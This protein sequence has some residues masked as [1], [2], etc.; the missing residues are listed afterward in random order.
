MS[1]GTENSMSQT[2]STSVLSTDESDQAKGQSRLTRPDRDSRRSWVIAAIAAI[3]GSGSLIALFLPL[4]PEALGLAACLLMLILIFLRMPVGVAMVIPS[5]LGMRAL[6]G[7]S[8]VEAAV[9]DVPYTAVANWTLSVVPMFILM[10]LLLWR[11]G[12]TTSVYEAGRQWLSWLPGGLAVGTNAAGAGLASV[13]GSTV[14]TTYALARTGIPEMLRAGYHKRVAISAVMTSGLPGQLIPPSILLVIYAGIA[15]VPVGPQL[16]A[17]VGPGVAVALMF[18]AMFVV[19]A[20]ARPSLT[21]GRGSENGDHDSG[22][23]MEDPSWRTRVR[24]LREVWPVPLIVA[25]IGWGIFSG[26]FTA[27]E[28]GALA[29]LLALVVTVI[30]QF[31]QGPFAAVAAAT[32]DAVSS[33]GAIFFI[34]LGVD[35]LSRMLSLSG[36]SAALVDVV[37]SLGLGRIEFLLVMTV[38]Y[39]ILGT[40][41]E[42]LPM[43][44]LTV[45]ALLPTLETLDISLIWFGVFVVFMGEIAVLSPPVGILAFIIHSIAQEPEVNLGQRITLKDVFMSLV[46]FL[47]IAVAF[48]VLIILVPEVVTYLPELTSP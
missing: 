20:M 28:A 12:L 4:Q 35:M 48:V 7:T 44:V 40:F 36:I 30:W 26:T 8:L 21:G 39:L 29:A 2:N 19:L 22:A 17:G 10:G 1:T 25:V 15:E 43:M 16:L 31:R 13:S 27:T 9:R 5:L 45:P 23:E 6:R 42:A 33:I 37:E 11:A 46:W 32:R 14:G 34:L 3:L 38:V 18:S 24:S 47:P 41:L